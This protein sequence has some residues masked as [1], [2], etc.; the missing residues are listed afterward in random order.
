MARILPL[1]SLQRKA[2]MVAPKAALGTGQT[3][4]RSEFM[5]GDK[6]PLEGVAID[7]PGSRNLL[8]K[9]VATG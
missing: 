7:G 8:D 3:E 1:L 4:P 9:P 5:I 6:P 2:T